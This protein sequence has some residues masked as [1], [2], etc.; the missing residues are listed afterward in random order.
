[1]MEIITKDDSGQID[2]IKEVDRIEFLKENEVIVSFEN[3]NSDIQ[4][5]LDD[6]VVVK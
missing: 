4:I 3:E 1:M 2:S 6:I 5:P